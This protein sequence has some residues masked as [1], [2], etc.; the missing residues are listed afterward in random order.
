MLTPAEVTGLIL[1]GGRSRRFGRDKALAE[2]EGVPMIVRAHAALDPLCQTVLVATGERP[3][4]YPVAARVVT[5]AVPDAGPLA[6]L[7]A[8]L[9]AAEAPWL[10]ALACDLP[11]VTAAALRPLLDAA[12]DGVDAAVAVDAAGR[13]HPTC[14]LYRVASVRGVAD[15]QLA[16]RALALR[17]LLDRL[18][19]REVA[20]GAVA[21]RNVNA[22]TDLG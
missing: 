21:L 17:A 11:F 8:G 15:E 9:A 14:A 20:L 10:L 13:R 6:G 5:D 7:S 12:A 2:V 22:P 4:A 3:R 19:V 1:A 16:Q 18:R